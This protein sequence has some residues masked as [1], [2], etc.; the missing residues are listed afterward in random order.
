VAAVKAVGVWPQPTFFAFGARGQKML[1]DYTDSIADQIK[2]IRC[3]RLAIDG[4][5]NLIDPFSGQQLG[6][7]ACRI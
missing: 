2:R 4:K 5:L 6:A 3:A 7:G 1:N